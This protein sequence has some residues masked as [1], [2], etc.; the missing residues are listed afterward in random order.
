MQIIR[1]ARKLNSAGRAVCVAIG[2]FDGVHLGHQQIVRQTIADALQQDGLSLVITFDRHP[3]AIV[4]PD[5]A[6]ALIEPLDARLRAIGTL[7]AS[8]LLLVRFNRQ[9]SE[10][11][12]E[13]FI[14]KLA[15]D[16]GRL[17]SICVGADFV[18]GHKR[19]GN[20]ELLRTLGAE[21]GYTVHG[22]AAVSLDGQ[23]V[24]STRIREAVRKGAFDA[25]SQMLGRT[26]ALTGRVVP[27]DHLGR[28]IG[29][30]TANLDV[31]GLVLPPNGVYAVRAV[32]A[33]QV[34]RGV[35][36]IGFR[37][38][39]NDPAPRLHAEVHLLDFDNDIY[40]EE[41]A[42]TF[43]ARLRDEQRFP[44]LEGLRAQ[45]ARDIADAKTRF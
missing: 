24:S 17:S 15:A 34:H 41:V 45:I 22:M 21:L 14:R 13:T 30:P 37:P 25:A 31:G 33:R 39:L 35:M 38:T 19:S 23:P 2:I 1:E 26:Y 43:V 16:L 9:F 8:A 5:H 11:P 32:A 29:F 6:P 7:G 44:S 36:N 18:F 42:V 40:E 27:G 20:V 10:Q 3:N 4:A 28:R 12:G